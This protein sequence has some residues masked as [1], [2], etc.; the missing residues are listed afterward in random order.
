MK[1]ILPQGKSLAPV[2]LGREMW[3]ANFPGQVGKVNFRN[4]DNN[5]NGNN[6]FVVVIIIIFIVSCCCCCC[7]CYS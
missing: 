1:Q 7:C 6:T 5:I 2:I 3:A 4:N